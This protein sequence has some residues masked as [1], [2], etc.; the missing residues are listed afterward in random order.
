MDFLLFST[1]GFDVHFEV[2][3]GLVLNGS[4]GAVLTVLTNLTSMFRY[5]L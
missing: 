5:F 4:L 1:T 2:H 3:F